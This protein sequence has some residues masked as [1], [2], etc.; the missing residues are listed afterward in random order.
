MKTKTFDCVEMKRKAAARIHQ[1]I[2][3][4]TLDE[5]VEYWRLRNEEFRAE[6][7][8][9]AARIAGAAPEGRQSPGDDS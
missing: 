6:Q 4:L 1:Q 2:G 8:D 9:L 3:H 7:E 5:K